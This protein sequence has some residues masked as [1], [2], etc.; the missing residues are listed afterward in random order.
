VIGSRLPAGSRSASLHA[1]KPDA[2]PHNDAGDRM[3]RASIALTRPVWLLALAGC[4]SAA[5]NQQG[6]LDRA[7]AEIQVQEARIEESAARLADAGVGCE[8]VNAAAALARQAQQAL[9]D[10]A[11]A[12]G[13]ADALIRCERADHRVASQE[14]TAQSRCGSANETR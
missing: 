6:V 10:A 7:F 3:T 9:C 5:P 11:R 8:A 2:T 1:P 4:A 12:V 14:T 13:D